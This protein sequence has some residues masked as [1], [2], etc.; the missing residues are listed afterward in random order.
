MKSIHR[1][2]ANHVHLKL[3]ILVVALVVPIPAT[4]QQLA[5]AVGIVVDN[6]YFDFWLPPA[7]RPDDNYTHGARIFWDSSEAPR[8]VARL[9]CRPQLACGAT[10]EFG[11]QIYTPAID[12]SFPVPGERT[13][14]GWLYARGEVRRGD[15]H[16]I[17]RVDVTIG[18]TGP[19]SLGEAS[20]NEL[21]RLVPGFR[22]PLGWAHQL[23]T[24]F[25]FAVRGAQS[26][27][28]KPRG[29]TG[30]VVDVVAT[31]NAAA[32]TLRT[33]VGVNARARVG[34][35]LT[36]P[37][38]ISKP[39]LVAPYAFIG[40]RGDA[41]GRD[42]FL[43]GSMFHE[44]ISVERNRIVTEWERGLGVRVRRL[45]LEYRAVTQSREYHSGPPKHSYG[46]IAVSWNLR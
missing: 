1:S 34:V 28:V 29:A 40:A 18:I 36:H 14:A 35:Q 38:L 5:R 30:R 2:R 32:G 46:S 13:Y 41:V 37:W 8:F 22:R 24:E 27:W 39:P 43:D 3:A 9:L 25:A 11:Q 44:S 15:F 17:R 10:A 31:T 7:Q 23:P 12:A 19:A 45:C 16:V 42:L 20:Q 26:W 33:A 21:H 4:A 6:D